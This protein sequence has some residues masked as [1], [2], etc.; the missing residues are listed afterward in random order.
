[1]TDVM[2]LPSQISAMPRANHSMLQPEANSASHQGESMARKRY[3][4]GCLR[5]RGK[6]E[7]QWVAMWREDVIETD[8][9]VRRV[10]R[11]EILGSLKEYKTRRL[12]QRAL[13]QRLTDVNSL[14]YKP[15]PTA[16]FRE[17]AEKWQKDV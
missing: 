16:T 3:Q 12:A 9:S 8:G 7:K 11:S 10:R 2:R 4:R 13:E 15:R 1:M 6:K 5:L 17:F 14:T